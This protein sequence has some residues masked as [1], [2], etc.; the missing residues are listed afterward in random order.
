MRSSRR[1]LDRATRERPGELTLTSIVLFTLGAYGIAAGAAS[2]EQSVVAVG[3][4]AFAL[5]VL[6]IIWPIVMLSGVEIEAWAPADATVG[7]RHD[8]HV[9][10]FGRVARVEL[11]LLDPP[12]EWWVTASP[13]ER[14]HPA[15]PRRRGV[16]SGL[17]IELRTS[18]PLGVFVR[19]RV[20]HVELPMDQA[21]APRPPDLGRADRSDPASPAT[22]VCTTVP[23]R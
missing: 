18:A 3:V 7:E 4:F 15:R 11:R 21:V 8:V 9:R 16:F 22:S 6:G 2:G 20:M 13:A 12:G 14:R 17:R 23:S 5:F 19:S 10:L 1:V